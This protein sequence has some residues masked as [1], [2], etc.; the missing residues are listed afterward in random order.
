MS[1]KI[2]DGFGTL[3]ELCDYHYTFIQDGKLTLIGRQF[4]NQPT[5]N[6]GHRVAFA[7]TYVLTF[8]KETNQ[9]E[10]HDFSALVTDENVEETFF[11]RDDK[12]YL[13]TFV[14]FGAM[15]F[16]KLFRWENNSFNE[17]TL[18][19]P[20]TKSLSEG[21]RTEVLCSSG[22]SSDGATILLQQDDD[23]NIQVYSLTVDGNAATIENTSHIAQD[24][25]PLRGLPVI[26]ET[27][28]DKVLISYGVHGCGFRWENSRL[29]IFDLKSNSARHVDIEGDYTELPRFCFTGPNCSYVN[30]DTKTWVV[31]A[32]SVQVGMTGS[33]FYGAV[34]ALKGNVFDENSKATWVELPQTVEQGEHVL[35][36]LT[37]YTI[38][39]D[40][41]SK[42]QL[43]EI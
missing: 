12:L 21:R 17:L 24:S 38:T 8:D 34:W 42:V 35:D 1:E 36:G 25:N 2:A 11:V 40:A 9:W 7:G 43:E 31:A 32:G 23:C 6:W 39:K 13:L 20:E 10:R 26:A 22:K 27:V 29:F 28:D 19:A 15:G 5:H 41:V 3:G 14:N 30:K 4:V 37:L 18:T 33:E 16:Q